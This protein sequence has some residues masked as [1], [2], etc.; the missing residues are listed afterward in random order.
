MFCTKKFR[1][2]W[3]WNLI[4]RESIDITCLR[5]ISQMGWPGVRLNI[6]LKTLFYTLY[7]FSRCVLATH[8][9]RNPYINI[10]ISLIHILYIS[11]FSF[12][13]KTG[14][15]HKHTRTQEAAISQSSCVNPVLLLDAIVILNANTM[16]ISDFSGTLW[17]TIIGAINFFNLVWSSWI[18]S[19]FAAV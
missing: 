1:W 6:I 3:I 4:A 14:Y 10:I 11:N 13:F 9:K 12:W 16:L 5:W 2:P 19:S 15:W 17:L 8:Y 18:I 7:R